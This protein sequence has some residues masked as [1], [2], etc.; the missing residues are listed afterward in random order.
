MIAGS[1]IRRDLRWLAPSSAKAVTPK[2]AWGFW[3]F[4]PSM[5]ESASENVEKRVSSSPASYV[6]VPSHALLLAVVFALGWFAA[7][8]STDAYS[9]PADSYGA[10]IET[11]LPGAAVGAN[12]V[13]VG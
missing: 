12:A 5:V 3:R 13:A 10:C 9:R 2:S 11:A 6:Q 1:V 7:A 4:S 8:P